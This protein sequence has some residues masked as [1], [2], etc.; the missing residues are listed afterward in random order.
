M[1]PKI[2]IGIPVYN[3]AE[4]LPEAVD[5]ALA[6]TNTSEIIIVDDGST[7]ESGKIAD[8]YIGKGVKVIHQVNKGLASARNTLIMNMTGDYLLPLDSDDMLLPH[9][10]ESAA[11][12][13]KQTK[14]DVVG[15]SFKCF[16][17]SNEQIILMPEPK[18]EDFKSGNR[19]GYCSAIKKEAL[20]AIGG[21]SPRMEEGYEDL[22]LWFNL[23]SRG[24]SI[25]TI[26]EV[27]WLYRIRENSMISRSVKFHDKLMAQIN[28]D[29][30]YA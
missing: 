4:F 5:S 19:L 2:T 16:G 28:K 6:Q 26:Q 25:I 15:L 30:L 27:L 14:S 23:L 22:H 29:F 3:Q 8:G 20:L 9:A 13:I 18:L 24:Y 17:L 10:V 12:V 11:Q 1:E 7:D 21:Y